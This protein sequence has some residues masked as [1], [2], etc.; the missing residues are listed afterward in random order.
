MM[1]ARTIIPGIRPSAF[2]RRLRRRNAV[3]REVRKGAVEALSDHI[4]RG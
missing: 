1:P 3:P 4:A 2:E